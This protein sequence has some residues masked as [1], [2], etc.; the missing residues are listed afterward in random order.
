MNPVRAR[1]ILLAALCLGMLGDIVSRGPFW[2]TGFAVCV[3][4]SA[5]AFLVIGGPSPFRILGEEV[6]RDRLLLAIVMILAGTALMLRSAGVVQVFNMLMLLS[7]AVLL[8]WRVHVAGVDLVAAGL[9]DTE[10]I[11]A[12][13]PT[14]AGDEHFHRNWAHDGR[15]AFAA[16]RGGW[17]G[18]AG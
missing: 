15:S 6:G 16:R 3:I 17:R 1:H 9:Q 8:V 4:A 7:A 5:V 2:P 11:E 14:C 12:D 18:R 13:L 10:E